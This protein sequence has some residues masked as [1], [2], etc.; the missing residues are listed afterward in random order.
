[1]KDLG[2]SLTTEQNISIPSA[3]SPPYTTSVAEVREKRFLFSAKLKD[4]LPGQARVRCKQ[5]NSNAVR[6]T[7]THTQLLVSSRRFA[8]AYLSLLDRMGTNFWWLDDEPHWVA[9]ILYE[10]A[11]TRMEKGL[12]FARWSGLVRKRSFLHDH[13]TVQNPE[14]AKTG[15][16]RT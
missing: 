8:T 12:A 7:H 1:V 4:G 9:R 5:N 3:A 6:I 16:G 15:S 2:L 11:A 13:F 10:H 14:Y